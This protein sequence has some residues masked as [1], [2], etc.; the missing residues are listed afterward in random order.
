MDRDL[1]SSQTKLFSRND[2]PLWIAIGVTFCAVVFVIIFYFT[3]TYRVEM[4]GDQVLDNL[5]VTDSARLGNDSSLCRFM[6]FGKVRVPTSSLHAGV[7]FASASPS[8]PVVTL[9]P[10]SNDA[11][12]SW[13][14]S[15]VT[16]NGFQV[17]GVK[18]ST[19][20]DDSDTNTTTET[21]P[22]EGESSSST[23]TSYVVLHWVAFAG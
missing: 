15:S 2:V 3:Q 23:T 20:A 1:L 22:D 4:E 13:S 9:T 6:A 19:T 18:H 7:T 8:A 12:V 14:V 5:L 21:G 17:A 11:P 10:E 16:T